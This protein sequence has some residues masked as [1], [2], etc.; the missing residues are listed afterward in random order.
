MELQWETIQLSKDLQTRTDRLLVM[1]GW[2]VK[3]LTVVI[4][5]EDGV[6][7]TEVKVNT[8]FVSDPAHHWVVDKVE[9]P[10]AA[11]TANTANPVVPLKKKASK[12]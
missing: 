5:N 9:V 1:A 6:N 7:R 10:M 11:N 8:T 3:T 2:L 12:K 4:V